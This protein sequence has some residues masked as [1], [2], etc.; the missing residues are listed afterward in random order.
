MYNRI[1][2]VGGSCF[3]KSTLCSILSKELNLPAIHLDGI[4]F[5]IS[6]VILKKRRDKTLLNKLF[7]I[8]I[9]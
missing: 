6:I 4:N 8:F 2:I 3:G 5:G 9:K 7:L 1:S